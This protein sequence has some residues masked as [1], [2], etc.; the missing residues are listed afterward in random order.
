MTGRTKPGAYLLLARVSNLPT[1]W[2]NVIAGAALTGARYPARNPTQNINDLK[3]QIAA[4]EKGA[5]ELRR[6]VAQF[7]LPADPAR[8]AVE[9]SLADPP[10]LL[11][12]ERRLGRGVEADAG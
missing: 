7:G 6:M 12:V 2:T 4:N 9:G 5:Q 8:S 10:T 3:A 11:V 1:I